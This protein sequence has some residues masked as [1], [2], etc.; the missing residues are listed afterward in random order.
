M[1]SHPKSS[2]AAS[3]AV[4]CSF[5]T[6]QANLCWDKFHKLILESFFIQEWDFSVIESRAFSLSDR[7]E[8]IWTVKMTKCVYKRACVNI[9]SCT[10]GAKEQQTSSRDIMHLNYENH[11]GNWYTSLCRHDCEW[12]WIMRVVIVT[13]WAANMRQLPL[14]WL[15]TWIV[16][17]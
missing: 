7:T 13:T 8:C 5:S 10:S 15:R 12:I 6:C 1:L 3:K 2:L 17:I 9:Y 14:L 16:I 11:R 4:T